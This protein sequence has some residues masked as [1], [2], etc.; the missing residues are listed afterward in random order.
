MINKDNLVKIILNN[1]VEGAISF[2][3]GLIPF[4]YAYFSSIFNNMT[5]YEYLKSISW[6]IYIIF[7]IPFIAMLIIVVIKSKMKEGTLP[8]RIVYCGFTTICRYN[9]NGLCWDISIS[10]DYD[11][12]P[13]LYQILNHFN[14]E[15]TP[16]CPKCG[17]KLEYSK[18]LLWYTWNCIECNF[19]YRTWN[20]HQKMVKR[21]KYLFERKLEKELEERYNDN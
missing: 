13:S 10:S 17:T 12:H 18:H 19:K 14:V 3:I 20:S 1:I 5:F 9:Y 16:R 7:F 15:D 11:D 21:V 2:I 8:F 6:Y 4:L